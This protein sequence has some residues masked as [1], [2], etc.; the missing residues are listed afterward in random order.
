MFEGPGGQKGIPKSFQKPSKITPKSFPNPPKSCPKHSK[1]LGQIHLNPAEIDAKTSQNRLQNRGLE[2]IPLEIAFRSQIESLIFRSWGAAWGV[3]KASGGR[4]KG[5][6]KAA[7]RRLESALGA[8]WRRL[9]SSWRR[10]E[11]ICCLIF[12]PED[13]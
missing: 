7:C 13:G 6:L 10:L 11:G 3:L 2:G 8:S 12:M 5:V 9:G 4:S 1:N